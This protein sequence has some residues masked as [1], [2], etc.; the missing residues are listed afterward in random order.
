MQR[1]INICM[2]TGI[3]CLAWFLCRTKTGFI[4]GNGTFEKVDVAI[5]ML[6]LSSGS[7][8]VVASALTMRREGVS[9]IR[10]W[11][12]VYLVTCAAYVVRFL[13]SFV[14]IVFGG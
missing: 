13:W 10:W 2:V 8:A 4:S 11:Q 6:L 1:V 7:V 9:T 3:L 5:G 14:L 12:W